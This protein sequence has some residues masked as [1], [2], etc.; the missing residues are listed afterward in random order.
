MLNA[1]K[2]SLTI[3]LPEEKEDLDDNYRDYWMVTILRPKQVIY[4]P[5]FMTS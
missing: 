2:K 4:F 1:K 3:D 5:N